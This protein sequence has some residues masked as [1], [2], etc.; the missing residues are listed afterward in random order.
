VSVV[1]GRERKLLLRLHATCSRHAD[2]LRALAQILQQRRLAHARL[3]AH[4][5]HAAARE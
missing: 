5:E 2:A 3:A 4:R 1:Q